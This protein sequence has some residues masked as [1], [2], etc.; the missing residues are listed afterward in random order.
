MV[1]CGRTIA[2]LGNAQ[3]CSK[4]VRLIAISALSGCNAG[5]QKMCLGSGMLFTLATFSE[6]GVYGRSCVHLCL[7]SITI[8]R[9]RILTAGVLHTY[10]HTCIHTNINTYTY[11]TYSYT[12][13]STY[14]YIYVYM[15]IYIYI[16]LYITYT[17]IHIYIY[18]YIHIYI[19]TYIHIYIYTYIHIHIYTYI[20]I[21]I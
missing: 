21:Y 12:Y 9:V 11:D 4:R 7:L 3:L 1:Y 18:T 15:Y 19:Y 6:S 13:T 14:N 17:Y 8:R 20:H 2:F 5:S 16:Y 10:I